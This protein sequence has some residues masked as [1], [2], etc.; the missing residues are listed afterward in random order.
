MRVPRFQSRGSAI[1]L[2]N[3]TLKLY[4]ASQVHTGVDQIWGPDSTSEPSV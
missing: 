1:L 2:A 3:R 4:V